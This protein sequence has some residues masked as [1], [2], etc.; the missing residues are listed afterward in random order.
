M[1]YDLD[2]ETRMLLY[3]DKLKRRGE[4][5]SQLRKTMFVAAAFVTAVAFIYAIGS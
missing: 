5:R 4:R 2:S 3:S 1:D